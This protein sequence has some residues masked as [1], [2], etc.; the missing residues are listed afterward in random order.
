MT[1]LDTDTVTLYAMGHPKVGAKVEEV[2]GPE[3]LAVTVI[4]RMEILRGRF[5][6]ILKAADDAQLNLAM[7]RFQEAEALLNSFLAVPSNDAAAK[8]FLALLK[9]KQAKKNETARH[10][11][12]LHR[13]GPAGVARHAERQGL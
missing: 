2:G 6:S 7:Q 12:C 8:Q 1:I 10:A 11:D 13:T 3:R 9:H 5:D 4:T